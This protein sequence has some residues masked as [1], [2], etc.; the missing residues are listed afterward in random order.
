[1]PDELTEQ[2]S[3]LLPHVVMIDPD[4]G[5]RRLYHIDELHIVVSDDRQV[6]RTRHLALPD[7]VV[8]AK[9]EKIVC[10]DDAGYVGVGIQ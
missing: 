1:M 5:E 10:C 2:V 8:N 4:G 6:V 3:R 9:C 7:D